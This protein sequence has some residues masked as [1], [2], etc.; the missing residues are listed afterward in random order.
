MFS[1]RIL[2]RSEKS[3]YNNLKPDSTI[4]LSG[5]FRSTAIARR[6]ENISRRKLKKLSHSITSSTE[7]VLSEDTP[8]ASAGTSYGSEDSAIVPQAVRE[9]EK[10]PPADEEKAGTPGAEEKSPSEETKADG[11]WKEFLDI[12]IGKPISYLLVFTPFAL[13]S[14]FLDWD[15]QWVFWL[16]FLTMIPLASILGD[17]TEE[18]ALHTND[19]VGGL[20]NASFGNAVEVVVAIQALL[21]NEIR[22]VQASMIGSIFS[23][24]L[25]VLGMCFFFGG[26]NYKEQSFHSTHVISAMGLLALSSIAMVLPTPFAE[27]YEV[28]DANVL[29]ISRASACF[30]MISYLMLVYFQ[31]FTHSEVGNNKEEAITP[32]AGAI[33][34]E[35]EDTEEDTEEDTDEEDEEPTIS[36]KMALFGLG[37]TTAL[38]TIFSDYL[39]E[40]IDGFC[41]ASGISRTFVGL[42]ILPIVGNAVEHI[43]AVSVAMKNKM[44]LAL[45]V[46]LGSSTQIALFVVPVT[47]IFGWV[48]DKPMTLNF[49]P[50]E[51]SLY[52]LSV[53]TVSV[54]LQSGKSNWLLGFVLVMTYVMVAI[55]FWFEK[56]ESF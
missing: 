13:A 43:T 7:Q 24:L 46:A 52:I 26:L 39:V 16:N 2:S 44:D 15:P 8:L 25:L 20:L 4:G 32:A 54:C 41:T 19:V 48:A 28:E 51:I 21:Q 18:A 31:L 6:V 9:K 45:G 14:H 42:I 53:F 29:A 38:V 12:W 40:S 27:Y 5:T 1:S 49:P 11:E 55:G 56:V 47:V 50:Y 10:P 22:V 34:K 30:L 33:A 37:L 23:N 17:F 3:F 36:M 35:G